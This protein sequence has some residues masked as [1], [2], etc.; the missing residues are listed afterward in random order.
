MRAHVLESSKLSG[1]RVWLSTA[2]FGS[3]SHIL[4]VKLAAD[5]SGNGAESI[6]E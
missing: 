3:S 5:A 2:V 6:V 4:E 1:L